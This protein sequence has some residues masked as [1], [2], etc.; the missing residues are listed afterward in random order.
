GKRAPLAVRG[1]SL[2]GIRYTLPVPSA[3]VK[4]ALLLAGLFAEGVTEVEEPVPTRDHTERLFRH[5]GL[6]LGVEGNRIRTRRAD[7]FPAQ[8]LVVPGDF[9]SAAFFLV[10]A[11]ITPG[12]E[13]VVE[14]VGLNPTRTGLLQVL[15][16]MGADLEWRVLEGEAGEP[17]GYIRAR[18]SPLKGVSVDPALI[19]LM[20]D[21]VPILAAAAA[22][23]EGETFIP[24]LSE[25][26]VKESD[27][28][29]AIAHNLRA[30]GVEVEPFHDHRIAMAFAV[31]GF[32]VGVRVWEPGWAEISYPGFF[33]DLLGLCGGS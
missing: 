8:D 23:A 13:V 19:P 9:S 2:R 10:A 1:A 4:S 28:V 31:A 33:R 25:L 14:G 3:Q 16:S 15:A 27:R 30:L 18:Y 29:A 7:P 17:V 20:V 22:W 21:E 26:R 32:P 11:L 5:F 24:N 12:S 6:P